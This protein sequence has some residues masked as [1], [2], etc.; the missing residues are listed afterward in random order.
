MLLSFLVAHFSPKL[1]PFISLESNWK[2]GII[3]SLL[4]ADLAWLTHSFQQSFYFK[5]FNQIPLC[6]TQFLP[7]KTL[8]HKFTAA[9]RRFSPQ[10]LARKRKH[11]SVH[12]NCSGLLTLKILYFNKALFPTNPTW[13]GWKVLFFTPASQL[14]PFLPP[15]QATQ[16]ALAGGVWILKVL[17]ARASLYLGFSTRC[18]ISAMSLCRKPGSIAVPPITTRFSASCFL[19]SMGH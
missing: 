14:S 18:L 6:S 11:H 2:Q 9:V 16:L 17:V 19:V 10:Q 5:H 13:K 8:P 3:C 1:L 7:Q 12:R 4:S 15:S